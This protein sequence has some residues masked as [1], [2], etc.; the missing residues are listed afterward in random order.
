MATPADVQMEEMSRERVL[1]GVTPGELLEVFAKRLDAEHTLISHRMT[2]AMTLNGLLLAAFGV[3]ATGPLELGTTLWV[4]TGAGVVGALSNLSVLYSNYWA[5]RAIDEADAALDTSMS[6]LA[7][8]A[9][10]DERGGRPRR[11]S[12]RGDESYR[13]I[14][15][16]YGRDPVLVVSRRRYP[17]L[18]SFHPWSLLPM[19]F[20]ATFVLLPMAARAVMSDP[21]GAPAAGVLVL[22]L[23]A[24]VAV[25]TLMV[26]H[27]RDHDSSRRDHVPPVSGGVLDEQSGRK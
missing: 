14:M 27:V 6:Q 10:K 18:R 21:P 7:L 5:G 23:L 26:M 1:E 9:S 17:V 22:P 15:R 24:T 13:S 19:L 11:A 12:T 2:W 25:A 20:V 4:A 16:L 3:V 8:R